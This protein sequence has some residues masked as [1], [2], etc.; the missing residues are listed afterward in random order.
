MSILDLFSSNSTVFSCSHMLCLSLCFCCATCL[1][2]NHH[3]ARLH[4]PSRTLLHF[5]AEGILVLQLLT[6][7]HSGT[8]F[9]ML[10]PPMHS[11]RYRI[12]F[13]PSVHLCLFPLLS[14]PGHSP[15]RY[16]EACSCENCMNWGVRLMK[17]GMCV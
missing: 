8:T 9:F 13:S 16:F 11:N 17:R 3:A 1:R 15:S 6:F 5:L 7:S 14:Q 12:S 2:T 4:T 10:A